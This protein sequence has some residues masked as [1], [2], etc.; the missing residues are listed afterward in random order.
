MFP[1]SLNEQYKSDNILELI[2]SSQNIKQLEEKIRECKRSEHYSEGLNLANNILH[3]DSEFP[4]ALYLKATILWEGFGNAE[5]AKGC[6]KKI[7]EKLP[8]DETLYRWA[9]TYFDEIIEAAE[10]E[11][12]K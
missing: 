5:G 4:D 8:E 12:N 3:K 9:S 7:K 11:E 10:N 1:L 6:L 2:L